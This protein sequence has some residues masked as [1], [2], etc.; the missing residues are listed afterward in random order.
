MLRRYL[1]SLTFQP[2]F[3]PEPASST[4]LKQK[5][6]GTFAA[7]DSGPPFPVGFAVDPVSAFGPLHP[8]APPTCIYSPS[9]EHG[10]PCP[11]TPRPSHCRVA[12]SDTRGTATVPSVS[13]ISLFAPPV[14]QPLVLLP[15]PAP[16][17]N[18]TPTLLPPRRI[19]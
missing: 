10:D 16:I 12:E 8:Y 3:P 18:H 14:Q 19:L 13:R 9:I 15:I 6:E 5:I 4:I 1:S 7:W 2:I 11:V 17:T